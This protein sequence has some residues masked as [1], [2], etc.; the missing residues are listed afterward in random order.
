MALGCRANFKDEERWKRDQESFLR[1]FCTRPA[2]RM[3][4]LCDED[5]RLT[6]HHTRTVQQMCRSEMGVQLNDKGVG[7]SGGQGEY[8]GEILLA[9][10]RS[11]VGVGVGTLHDVLWEEE[12]EVMMVWE[13]IAD[14]K[15][16]RPLLQTLISFT[17]RVCTDRR[18]DDTLFQARS[19]V[20]DIVMHE[21][22]V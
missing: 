19:R 16:S 3:A 8:G 13:E 11:L 5:L 12:E 7:G 15:T 20:R 21:A 22:E 18:T 9:C 1:S 2:L 14:E 4:L 17:K 6:W 10:S